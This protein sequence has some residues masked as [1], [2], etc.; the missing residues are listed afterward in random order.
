MKQ[1]LENSLAQLHTR[2]NYHTAISKTNWWQPCSVPFWRKRD[3][4]SR[5][6]SRRFV[7]KLQNMDRGSKRLSKSSS[8]NIKIQNTQTKTNMPTQLTKTEQQ[9]K[10]TGKRD[11]YIGWLD[12]YDTFFYRSWSTASDKPQYGTRI[13]CWSIHEILS[14]AEMSHPTCMILIWKTNA[15]YLNW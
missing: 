11:I 13:R 2:R 15:I 6:S 9:K 3:L 14:T 10:T 4:K 8:I 7:G 5:L 12:L 1:V